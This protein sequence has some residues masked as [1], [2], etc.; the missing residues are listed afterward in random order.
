MMITSWLVDGDGIICLANGTPLVLTLDHTPRCAIYLGFVETHHGK[1]ILQTANLPVSHAMDIKDAIKLGLIAAYGDGY[2]TKDQRHLRKISFTQ[3]L[4]TADMPTLAAITRAITLVRW[5][6]DHR[7]C[8]RCGTKAV[9]HAHGEHAKVCPKCH[10]HAYPRVQPCVIV[11]ITRTDTTTGKPQILL[12]QHQRHKVQGVY[13]LIAGFV[14]SGETLEMA[15]HREVLEEVGLCIDSPRYFG[16]QS[17][18]YPSN[19]MAGFVADYAS[20][21]IAI[22]PDELVDAQFFD[23]DN[24]PKI[25]RTGTIAHALICHVIHHFNDKHNTPNA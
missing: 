13:G 17:W 11:A 15:A 8:S 14:E 4:D 25:P 19:L 3:F 7:F 5:Q 2:D 12:A 21:T 10:Y 1:P 22:C 18:P 23:F 6:N 24:L 16:S 9:P 20:G